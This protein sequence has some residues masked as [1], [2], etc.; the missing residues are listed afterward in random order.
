MPF[1]DGFT[2]VSGP[3]EVRRFNVLSTATFKA[4]APVSIGGA[5]T[6]Q[7]ST[8]SNNYIA[9]IAMNDAANSIYGS[10][11]LVMIPNEQTV[12]ATICDT[13]LAASV[14][15]AGFSYNFKKSGNNFRLDT[16]SQATARV[17]IVPRGD[18]TT[19]NSADSSVFVQ[20]LQ[21]F[22]YPYAS[23]ASTAL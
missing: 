17:T 10:E 20:F 3:Y 21:T 14:L 19:I 5:R 13:G 22:V 6:I 9:G 11:I 12:F 7:E 4:R 23:L 16:A 1:S 18:G 15:S 8:A 2:Y